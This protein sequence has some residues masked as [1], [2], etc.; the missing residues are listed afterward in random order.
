MT[1]KAQERAELRKLLDDATPGPWIHN[2]QGYPKPDV[3][4]ACGRGV[5]VTWGTSPK[6][7]KSHSAYEKRVAIDRANAAYIAAANP[8]KTLELLDGI[9]RLTAE[10]EAEKTAKAN[11]IQQAQI[12]KMEA[13]TQRAIVEDELTK[14]EG[15]LTRLE[16]LIRAHLKGARA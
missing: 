9:D 11:A 6:T 2:R 13:V 15:H 12:W 8:A 10:L 14:L 1:T 5:A 7:P 4:G 3:K 16:A